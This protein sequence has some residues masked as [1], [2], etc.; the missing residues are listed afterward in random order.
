MTEGFALH[1][2]VTDEADRPV[3]YRF[4]DLNPAFERLTGLTRPERR[5][6]GA[7]GRC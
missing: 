1:E 7:S 3:D 4:I 5:W 2:I 6:A